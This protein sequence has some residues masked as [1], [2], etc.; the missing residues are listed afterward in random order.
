MTQLK[1]IGEKYQ[2]ADF[3]GGLA[4]LHELWARLPD[5]KTATPNAY[6]LVEY[7]VVFA[8]KLRDFHE[9]WTWANR[10]PD[11]KQVRQD[12][13]EVE[14]LIGK[15]AFEDS[16]LDLAVEQFREAHRKSRGRAFI[17][18]DPKYKA[19]IKKK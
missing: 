6:M 9:A 19:L 11:F 16:K 4:L 15:V 5:P 13:G 10:A 2:T 1:P 12:I 7:G 17:D 18:V 3:R 14:F 8:L